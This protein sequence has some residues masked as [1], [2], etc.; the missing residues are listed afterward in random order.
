MSK[1]FEFLGNT[2]LGQLLTLL[3]TEF[4]K[5]LNTTDY[6]SD[7][8]FGAVKVDNTTIFAS[9]GVISAAS[10]AGV[11]SVTCSTAASTAT[12]EVTISDPNFSLKTGVCISITFDNTNTATT[13]KIKINNI[14]AKRIKYQG[15]LVASKNIF[16]GGIEDV[17]ISYVYDGTDFIYNGS[18]ATVPV[19]EMDY[20]DYA[21]L[22]SDQ[23][24]DGIMRV[25]N[26]APSADVDITASTIEVTIPGVPSVDNVEDAIEYLAEQ[27]GTTTTAQ[28]A[29]ADATSITIQNSNIHATSII[30]VYND[31][32]I[33]Y[34][35]I[36]TTEGQCVVTFDALPSAT[37]FRLWIR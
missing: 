26:N 12:K 31:N 16:V 22:T 23:L 3:K 33:E 36:T 35:T 21:Q 18:D 29:A 8:A 4:D 30:E 37:N 10:S 20:L 28:S 11:Y 32:D 14:G 13:P 27:I 15:L 9:N 25:V 19:V 2:S 1:K 24:N 5:K 6:A 17:T 34:N 7:S